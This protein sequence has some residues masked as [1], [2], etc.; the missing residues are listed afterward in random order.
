MKDIR[1]PIQLKTLIT[2][3][4]GGR[5]ILILEDLSILFQRRCG[6]FI[7]CVFIIFEHYQTCPEHAGPESENN[8]L[9]PNFS[10]D[11]GWPW[12]KSNR[13]LRPCSSPPRLP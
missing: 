13:Y 11:R 4:G 6:R 8:M 3:T 9:T 5:P 1:T 10:T 12:Q 7:S 2:V